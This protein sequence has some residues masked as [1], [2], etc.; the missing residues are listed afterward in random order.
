MAVR[1]AECF[2]PSEFI[3]HVYCVGCRVSVSANAT[4]QQ[5]SAAEE[6]NAFFTVLTAMRTVYVENET[7]S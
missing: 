2:L 7:K 3:E 5:W 6:E 4:Y 1:S